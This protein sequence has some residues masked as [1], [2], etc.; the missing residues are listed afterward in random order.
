MSTGSETSSGGSRIQGSTPASM[1]AQKRASAG[2]KL[3]YDER[4][5][6][7]PYA[8]ALA[9]GNYGRSTD[10]RTYQYRAAHAVINAIYGNRTDNVT[11]A[12]AGKKPDAKPAYKRVIE[13]KDNH[14]DII[15]VRVTAKIMA[16]RKVELRNGDW[17]EQLNSRSYGRTLEKTADRAIK[18]VYSQKE[19]D[20][21]YRTVESDYK[22]HKSR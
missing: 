2:Y 17:R 18:T 13:P 10:S 22:Y 6:V 4:P 16:E 12:N 21:I 7:S 11:V 3:A 20:E 14:D 15:Q 19:Q 9:L 8:L 5:A 1:R